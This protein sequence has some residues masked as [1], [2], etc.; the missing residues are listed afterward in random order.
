MWLEKRK[1]QQRKNPGKN[2]KNKMAQI[3]TKEFMKMTETER[4]RR[5]EELKL[6]LVKSNVKGKTGSSKKKEIK[7]TIARLITAEKL[8]K[9]LSKQKEMLKK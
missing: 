8:N 2:Q 3:K 7:K 1:K 4:Q 9:M 6:E 5:L